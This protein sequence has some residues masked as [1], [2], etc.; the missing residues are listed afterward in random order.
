[1]GALDKAAQRGRGLLMNEEEW[2]EDEERDEEMGGTARTG[3]VRRA[4]P[5]LQDHLAATGS[6]EVGSGSLSPVIE[7]P[8][9]IWDKGGSKRRVHPFLRDLAA[10]GGPAELDGS[11]VLSQQVSLEFRGRISKDE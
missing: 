3:G 5:F 11:G 10:T 2:V 7:E 4:H 9:T 8:G 6:S 1:M